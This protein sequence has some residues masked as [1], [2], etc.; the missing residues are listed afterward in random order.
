MRTVSSGRP[1]LR[2]STWASSKRSC[3]ASHRAYGRCTLEP[4]SGMSCE[5]VNASSHASVSTYT[6][7]SS[8]WDPIL[9]YVS[10]AYAMCFPLRKVAAQRVRFAV[11]DLSSRRTTSMRSSA[12]S[13]ADMMSIAR[14]YS[15]DVTRI[16]AAVR[17]SLL[18]NAHCACSRVSC[19][20]SAPC[21][22]P[23]MKRA[24]S[25]RFR[26]ENILI[27]RSTRPALTITLPASW[28][29]P[30]IACASPRNTWSSC[31][32]SFREA[33]TRLMSSVKRTSRTRMNAFRAT[34]RSMASSASW[35]RAIQ[36]V[37]VTP[38]VARR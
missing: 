10:F 24:S 33:R 7:R 16:E 23:A 32:V 14:P 4:S 25:Q 30:I 21:A 6:S 18:C 27:A 19:T 15:S 5:R 8:A 37:S 12:R 11:S 34:S 9:M 38:I 1:A 36:S 17:Q 3:D 35:A 26:S 22:V 31:P 20:T 13:C 29:L 28:K 2:N